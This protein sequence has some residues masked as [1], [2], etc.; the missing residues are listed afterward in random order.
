MRSLPAASHSALR[1]SHSALRRPPP[2]SPAA[3][4]VSTPFVWS[5]PACAPE[6]RRRVAANDAKARGP[7]AHFDCSHAAT[8]VGVRAAPVRATPSRVPEGL[9]R[10]WRPPGRGRCAAGRRISGRGRRRAPRRRARPLNGRNAGP[11]AT[12]RTGGRRRTRAPAGRS[13]CTTALGRVASGDGTRR[14]RVDRHCETG[15]EPGNP[16]IRPAGRAVRPPQAP[17]ARC[18]AARITSSGG[19]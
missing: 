18:T 9:R 7:T 8:G 19:A 16:G 11:R 17:K 12:R 14:I 13:G 5:F 2:R 15:T 1:T 10:S 3:P 4:P 6:A